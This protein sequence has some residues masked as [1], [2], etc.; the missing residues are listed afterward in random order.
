MIITIDGVAASGKSSTARAVARELDLLHLDSGALYRAFAHAAVAAAGPSS[1]AEAPAALEAAARANVT[2]EAHD[3]GLLV[4]LDGRPLES[5]LRTARV[6][7]LASRIAVRPEIRERVNRLLRGAASRH[8]R[9]AVCEGRDMGTAVFPDAD[10]KVYLTAS[11]GERAR[12]RL[13]ERGDA[14]APEALRSETERL[15]ARDRAD[16]ERALAPLRKPADAV[17]LD[18]TGLAFEE[19]V[20]RIVRLARERLTR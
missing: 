15:E 5:E 17:V 7:A 11:P 8:A 13:R 9:G 4:R 18:T 1:D 20:E 19:Q 2:V 12:R 14:L 6:T 3:G 10:L 16:M